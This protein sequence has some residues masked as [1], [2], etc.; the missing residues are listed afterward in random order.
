[1]PDQLNSNH[2][3]ALGLFI[4][5]MDGLAYQELDRRKSW[6]HGKNPRFGAMDAGQ[7]TGPAEES[8]TLTGMLVPEVAGQPS[9][10]DTLREMGDTGDAY[11]LVL[12]N[13]KVLGNY[14]IINVDDRWRNLIAGGDAR[15]IDF[16][17]D[18]DRAE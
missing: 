3:I 18:L 10:I 16:A 5:G 14:R 7:F 17:L 6:R 11:P 8:I 15:A 9:D 2:L 12:G 4:F 13:G 1:M